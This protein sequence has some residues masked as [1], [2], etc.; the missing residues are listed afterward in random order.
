M[1]MSYSNENKKRELKIKTARDKISKQAIEAHAHKKLKKHKTISSASPQDGA[2]TL[3]MELIIMTSMTISDGQMTMFHSIQVVC[4]RSC[5]RTRVCLPERL[6]VFSDPLALSLL[7]CYIIILRYMLACVLSCMS[8]FMCV[9]E[10]S[11]FVRLSFYPSL[12]PS[13]TFP[14]SQNYL[15]P[16]PELTQGRG[17]FT[18]TLAD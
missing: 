9:H 12:G 10:K 14:N 17:E 18:L 4:A 7:L 6:R 8:A 15:F 5:V 2:A 11:P 1:A 3:L 16:T 13:V